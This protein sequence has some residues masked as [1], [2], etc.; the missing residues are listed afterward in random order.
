MIKTGKR[1]ETAGIIQVLLYHSSGFVES[2]SKLNEDL[3]RKVVVTI[4][5]ALKLLLED[6]EKATKNGGSS[7]NSVFIMESELGI[8]KALT[9][10]SNTSS[11]I[12]QLIVKAIIQPM[13][14]IL[15]TCITMKHRHDDLIQPKETPDDHSEECTCSITQ[16]FLRLNCHFYQETLGKRAEEF[17]ISMFVSMDLKN[18]LSLEYMRYF[19]FMMNDE[20]TAQLQ[21]TQLGSIGC[22]ITNT[23][24]FSNI[25]FSNLN[26]DEFF[27]MVDYLFNL[28]QIPSSFLNTTHHMFDR[29]LRANPAVQNTFFSKNHYVLRYLEICKKKMESRL[30]FTASI[31]S[32]ELDD[33]FYQV[34]ED[35]VL[36]KAN[37]NCY[38][39]S[40]QNEMLVN[41]FVKARNFLEMD[42]VNLMKGIVDSL[43]NPMGPMS[44]Q[45]VHQT[46]FFDITLERQF[47]M[48]MILFLGL[49]LNS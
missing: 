48:M 13:K 40:A 27:D 20:E 21:L 11:V 29:L 4:C 24:H 38:F 32:E 1:K 23:E 31:C 15:D 16:L 49:D 39:I 26:L 3:Q 36:K 6:L 25:I 7:S 12:T 42:M 22:F 41:S 44:E 30:E 45:Y 43:K 14:S 5:K 46:V 8:L 19:R 18:Y 34:F 35:L 28:P 9:D 17:F 2:P 33:Y 47:V 10:I 37:E